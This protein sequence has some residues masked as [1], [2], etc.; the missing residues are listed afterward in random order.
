MYLGY[1]KKGKNLPKLH[2]DVA[3]ARIFKFP[4]QSKSPAW[5][6]GEE[7]TAEAG[8]ELLPFRK[9]F[10]LFH[11]DFALFLVILVLF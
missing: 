3:F 9:Y 11:P 1:I 8:C 6:G 7:K 4:V 10:K 5:E 2:L